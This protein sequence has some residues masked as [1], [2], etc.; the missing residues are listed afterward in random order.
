MSRESLEHARAISA[1]MMREARLEEQR[2]AR[3]I[4]R[5][6]GDTPLGMVYQTHGD[7]WMDEEQ[8]DWE[9]GDEQ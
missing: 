5:E 9:E 1:E 3:R 7:T 4:R 2:E 6:Y 8:R